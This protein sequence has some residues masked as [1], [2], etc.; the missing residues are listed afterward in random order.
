M[1]GYGP[2]LFRGGDLGVHKRD[3]FGV[4][5]VV[6]VWV[7]FVALLVALWID[8]RFGDNTLERISTDSMDVHADLDT[9]CRWGVAL[10]GGGDVYDAGARLVNL[11]PPFWTVLIAPLGLLEPLT[12]YRTFVLLTLVMVMGYLAW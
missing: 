1:P 2:A 8:V 7:A 4:W 11:N 12:T 9:F 5:D 3:G 6:L 10:W